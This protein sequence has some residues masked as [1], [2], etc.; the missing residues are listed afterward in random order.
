MG[1][2]R[3]PGG[4]GTACAVNW[5]SADGGPCSEEHRCHRRQQLSSSVPAHHSSFFFC[6]RDSPVPP[7]TGAAAGAAAGLGPPIIFLTA[8]QAR[9]QEV[10]SEAAGECQDGLAAQLRWEGGG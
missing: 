6:S 4:N 8:H 2:G 1:N 10:A 3:R 7:G 5:S 9:R